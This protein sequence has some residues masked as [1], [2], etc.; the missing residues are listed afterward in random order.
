LGNPQE[1]WRVLFRGSHRIEDPDGLE[2]ADLEHSGDKVRVKR[3]GLSAKGR[4]L[5]LVY[6]ARKNKDGKETYRIIS[7]RRE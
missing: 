6:T 5:I 7:V 2:W 1:A 4:I 3:L